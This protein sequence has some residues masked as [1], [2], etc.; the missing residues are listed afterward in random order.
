M[1][2]QRDTRSGTNPA[3]L[4]KECQIHDAEPPMNQLL[5]GVISMKL[6]YWKTNT[7]DNS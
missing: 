1:L 4:S 6:E 3:W 5:L 7:A 2:L